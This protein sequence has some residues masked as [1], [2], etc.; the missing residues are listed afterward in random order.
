MIQT[1]CKHVL[2]SGLISS[3]FHP[4]CVSYWKALPGQSQG[5]GTGLFVGQQEPWPASCG[6]QSGQWGRVASSCDAHRGPSRNTSPQG[7]PL[8]T[9]SH[10]KFTY[11]SNWWCLI[12]WKG[13]QA[14]FGCWRMQRTAHV[15]CWTKACAR[16]WCQLCENITVFVFTLANREWR[17]LWTVEN[18]GKKSFLAVPFIYSIL[19]G[20]GMLAA[21]EHVICC[22]KLMHVWCGSLCTHIHREKEEPCR[23]DKVEGPSCGNG[24]SEWAV[25]CEVEQH[26]LGT[27]DHR[28]DLIAALE[29]EIKHHKMF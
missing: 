18:D 5:H 15:E 9:H 8:A 14:Q 19:S 10:T 6:T 27:S 3:R 25:A 11:L 23:V 16:A 20:R 12:W 28:R 17:G 24:S 4:L 22:C 7:C 13:F 2:G 26:L 29:N 1:W 21:A